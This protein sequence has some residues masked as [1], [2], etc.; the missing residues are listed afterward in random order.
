MGVQYKGEQPYVG[1]WSL[2]I[3]AA[4]V[5]F[6]LVVLVGKWLGSRKEA[7]AQA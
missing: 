3:I 6:A 1:G 4:I 5:G 7:A 2:E